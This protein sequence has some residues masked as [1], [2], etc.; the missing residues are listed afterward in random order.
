MVNKPV[1]T[2]APTRPNSDALN[3]RTWV[4]DEQFIA[5][6]WLC[7]FLTYTYIG[8]NP[9]AVSEP[10]KELDESGGANVIRQIIFLLFW[11]G[12]VVLYWRNGDVRNVFKHPALWVVMLYATASVGWSVVPGIAIRRVLLLWI[13]TTTLFM[14]TDLAGERLLL[15]LARTHL[16]LLLI[17]L[18]SIPL[19]KGARHTFVEEGDPM[20]VGNWKGIFQH[21][22][23]AGPA[24]VISILLFV[25]AYIRSKNPLWMLAIMAAL[26]FLGFTRSKTTMLLLL[27]SLAA[28]FLFYVS[29]ASRF[30]RLMLGFSMVGLVISIA[31]TQTLWL[32]RLLKILE[33]PEAFTGRAMIWLTMVLAL[34]N[35]WQLGMGYGSVWQVGESN[36][37]VYFTPL[38]ADWVV[39]TAHGHNGYLDVLLSM[40]VVGFTLVACLFLEPIIR[41]FLGLGSNSAFQGLYF[42]Y[43]A[44]FVLGNLTESRI[45]VSDSSYWSFFL[46]LVFLSKTPEFYRMEIKKPHALRSNSNRAS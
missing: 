2:N 29:S 11:S 7:L 15:W 31:A 37:L 1:S 20:L 19:L 42:G 26:I 33:D 18:M 23:T 12:S 41:F 6:L 43:L 30:R 3:W 5:A 38:Y 32:P 16:L 9:F 36:V 21:K 40:G 44:F 17:S 25:F 24:Q 22:N 39:T 14:L 45:L 35:Y 34:P 46:I 28:G 13:T 10:Q 8:L 27:P 4:I